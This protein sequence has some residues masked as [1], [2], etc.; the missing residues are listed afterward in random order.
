MNCNDRSDPA[1]R[2]SVR[3]AGSAYFSHTRWEGLSN[4]VVPEKL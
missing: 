1:V 4:A 2:N 3:M